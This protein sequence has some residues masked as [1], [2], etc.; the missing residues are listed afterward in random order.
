MERSGESATG[1]TPSDLA[2]RILEPLGY[3]GTALG[4]VVGLMIAVSWYYQHSNKASLETI[5]MAQKTFSTVST[6]LKGLAESAIQNAKDVADLERAKAAAT[7]ERDLVEA[8]KLALETEKKQLELE[9]ADLR[10]EREKLDSANTVLA[11]RASSY[12]GELEMLVRSIGADDTSAA[13]EKADALREALDPRE[14][15]RKWVSGGEQAGDVKSLVGFEA[16]AVAAAMQ[17]IPGACWVRAASTMIDALYGAATQSTWRLERVVALRTKGE[18]IAS[19]DLY[20]SMLVAR[21]PSPENWDALETRLYVVSERTSYS[22]PIALAAPDTWTLADVARDER[23]RSRVDRIHC[24]MQPLR[25]LDLAAAPDAVGEVNAERRS[26]RYLSTV[27]AMLERSQQ[28]DAAAMV[29]RVDRSELRQTFAAVVSAAVGRNGRAQLEAQPIASEEWGR[30]AAILLSD[31][32]GVR[33][34]DHVEQQ[35]SPDSATIQVTGKAAGREPGHALIELLRDGQGRWKVLEIRA[36]RS[37]P[38]IKR[39]RS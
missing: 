10:G 30:L 16:V 35:A 34:L 20:D 27:A 39:A 12:L 7:R 31:E 32:V 36:V 25:V 17:E 18:V 22:G 15:L 6:E 14:I 21:H 38:Q 29:A 33:T 23:T 1:R 4:V 24:E 19:V 28:L 3:F 13:R 37:G 26:D 8:Q 5:E 2:W 11:N 9:M